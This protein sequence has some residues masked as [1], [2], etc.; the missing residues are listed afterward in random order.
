ME[1]PGKMKEES[2]PTTVNVLSQEKRVFWVSSMMVVTKKDGRLCTCLDL[3]CLNK[4]IMREHYPLPSVEDIASSIW[5][6]HWRLHCLLDVI[7]AGCFLAN[8]QHRSY[9]DDEWIG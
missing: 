6:V 3:K 8:L 7:G 4:A 1:M 2:K 5:K 9:F